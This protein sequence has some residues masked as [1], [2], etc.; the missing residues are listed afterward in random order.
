MP[1]AGG[2]LRLHVLRLENAPANDVAKELEKTLA[3]S[4]PGS[5]GGFKVAVQPD[6]N[7][8]VLSGTPEQIK[9]ALDVVARLDSASGR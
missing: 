4:H 2:E 9:E 8:L 1:E 7:A 3:S 6:Q 5:G